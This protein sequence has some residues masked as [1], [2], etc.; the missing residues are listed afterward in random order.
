MKSCGKLYNTKG[1]KVF[2][3]QCDLIEHPILNVK[4]CGETKCCSKQKVIWHLNI[5]QLFGSYRK[6]KIIKN[7]KHKTY[8]VSGTMQESWLGKVVAGWDS[9]RK[10]YA[11]E[12]RY[13]AWILLLQDETVV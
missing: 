9:V 1:S 8:L 6:Q 5:W 12:E 13:L 7:A 3:P 11:F 2:F 4:L 10:L